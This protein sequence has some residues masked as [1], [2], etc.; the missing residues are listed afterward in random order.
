[1]SIRQTMSE[2]ALVFVVLICGYSTLIAAESTFFDTCKLIQT[3]DCDT[4]EPH[5][6]CGT[7][8]ITYPNRCVFAKA[9][10]QDPDIHYLHAG[11]CNQPPTPGGGTIHPPVSTTQATHEIV[12]DVYCKAILGLSCAADGEPVCASDGVRYLS[13]CFFQKAHC[14]DKSL[15]IVPCH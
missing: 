12:Q 14:K 8:G 5:L 2:S 7:N 10:C 6:K 1:M 3:L 11:S 4:F 9:H 15:S 13:Q